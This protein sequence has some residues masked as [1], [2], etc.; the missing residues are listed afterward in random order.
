MA[1]RQ[2][3]IFLLLSLLA[4]LSQGLVNADVEKPQASS[5]HVL[6]FGGTGRTGVE[7][8][9]ELRRQGAEVTV[10]VRPTSDRTPIESLGVK[11]AVGDDWVIWFVISGLTS[12]NF[13]AA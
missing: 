5:E 11:F 10:F 2:L 4:T 3:T 12:V 13:Q 8:V 6:V 7:V 1:L 9:R